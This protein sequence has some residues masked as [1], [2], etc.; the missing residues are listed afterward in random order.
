MQRLRARNIEFTE[1]AFW[2]ALGDRDVQTVEDLLD[3]GLSPTSIDAD[4][5]PPLH[6]IVMSG[7]DYG[8][9]TADATRRIVA[10]LLARGADPNQRDS[11]GG[12]PVLHR[13]SSC[14]ATLVR[15]LIAA[16]AD[17]RAK[18]AMQLSAF[19]L[20]VI[21]SPDAAAALLDAGYRPD[22]K[23]RVT[24]KAMHDAERD[25]AKRKVLARALGSK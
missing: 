8:K 13:A 20:F 14:D 5:M 2:R 12:N 16:K 23:E 4:G 17:L 11:A 21:G 1:D 22:A 18:N 9:P 7:C 3:A 25:P 24:V 15:Q 6:V 10:A 19:T